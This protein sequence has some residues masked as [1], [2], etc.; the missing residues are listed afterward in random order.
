MWYISTCCQENQ[1]GGQIGATQS[2]IHW[3]GIPGGGKTVQSPIPLC[4][5]VH[6]V[7]QRSLV[8]QGQAVRHSAASTMGITFSPEQTQQPLI[9]HYVIQN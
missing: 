1:L 9:N 7:P 6:S 2:Q 3:L 4:R 8:V 5:L